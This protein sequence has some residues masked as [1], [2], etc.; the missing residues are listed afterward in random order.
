M[1]RVGGCRIWKNKAADVMAERL[2]DIQ[3]WT[4]TGEVGGAWKKSNKIRA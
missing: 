4:R 1:E 3:L 2:K